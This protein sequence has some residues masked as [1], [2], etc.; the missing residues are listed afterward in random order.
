[1]TL[2]AELREGL[3]IAWSAVRANRLR[4]ALTTLGIVIGILT[5]TLMA[6]AIAGL[7]RAFQ[8]SVSAIGADVL[9]VQRMDWIIRSHDDWFRMNRRRRL[10]VAQAEAIQREAGFAQAVTPVAQGQERIQF[11]ARNAESVGV[12]GT[13]ESYAISSGA[14]VAK[15]RFFT[16][17]EAEGGRPVCVQGATVASNLFQRLPPVGE[18]VTLGGRNFDVVGVL[19][20]VGGLFGEGGT[21]GQVIIPLRAFL[22]AFHS[23]PDVVLQVKVGGALDLDEA[24]EELRQIVRKVRRLAPNDADDFSIN[25]QEQIVAAFYS[26]AGTIAG[27]GLFITGLSLFVGG[28]GIMNIMFVSVAERTK[29]IGI[30]KAIGARRRT[31]LLQFLLEAA[32]IC[33]LGGLIGLAIAWPVTLGMGKFIPATLS[34][35]IVT[36]ALAVAATTGLVSGFLPA[37][38]AARLDPV[39]ALRAE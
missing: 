33:V 8:N 35:F 6:T 29:E 20:P 36:L 13:T 38:R 4:S 11:R 21:D 30:R 31:I 7:N 17:A 2:V 25:Q 1:M 14:G 10:T 12:V 32:L 23:N 16:A 3:R 26:I 39:E 5:V 18:R 34:P 19:E 27:V 24:R 9:Y 22:A 37:W 28:I 15:G